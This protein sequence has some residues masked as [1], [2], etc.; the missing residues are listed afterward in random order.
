MFIKEFLQHHIG[1]LLKSNWR[2]G[3]VLDFVWYMNDEHIF[4]ILHD[5]IDSYLS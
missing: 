1:K 2:I 5:E 4:I 3:I